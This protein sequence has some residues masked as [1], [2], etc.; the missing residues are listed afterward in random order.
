[1]LR[2]VKNMGI[3]EAKYIKARIKGK[4][5][6]LAAMDATGTPDKAVAAVQGN[7]L[8]KS[9]EVKNELQRLL[10][11]KGI[12]LD[13]ALQPIADG[14]EA[15]KLIAM[16]KGED[17]FIDRI[18][19]M[20]TRLQASDR[21]LKLLNITSGKEPQFNPQD[22]TDALNNNVDEVELTHAVFKRKDAPEPM[23]NE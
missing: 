12:T 20:P 19:D 18:P 22:L 10:K 17:S 16:G 1:M 3:K 15:E 8:E 11:K 7:R 5:K 14:L 23:S 4:N 13:K 6:T 21:A 9:P 2:F